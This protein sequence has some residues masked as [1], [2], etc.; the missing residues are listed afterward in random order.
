[1]TTTR[2]EYPFRYV[3]R[4]PLDCWIEITDIDRIPISSKLAQAELLDLNK[5][6]CK[7]KSSLDLQVNTHVITVLVHLK[8][9]ETSLRFPGMIRWQRKMDQEGYHYGISMKLREEE[10]E[11]LNIELRKLAGSQQIKVL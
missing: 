8:F 6:G 9:N 3:M 1:M 5:G 7:V 4:N 10:R 11:M 2:R